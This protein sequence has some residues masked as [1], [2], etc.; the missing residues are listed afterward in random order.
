MLLDQIINNYRLQFYSQFFQGGKEGKLER[1]LY[2]EIN[3]V[4]VIQN[5]KKKKFIFFRLLLSPKNT[6]IIRL[7]IKEN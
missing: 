3:L 7:W 2:G 6:K 4:Y 5:L 1:L